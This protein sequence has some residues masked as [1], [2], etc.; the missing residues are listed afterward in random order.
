MAVSR[1]ETLDEYARHLEGDPVEAQALY[2]DCLISVTSFFR[3]PAVSSRPS[4]EQVLPLLLKDRPS[5]APLR[6][7]VPGCA[8]GE[9]VYSIA[10]CLLERTA[11]AVRATRPCRSSRTDLSEGALAEGAGGHLP[12]EHR[13][14]R[15]ARAP[16]ALLRQGGAASYQ[17]SKTIRE[18]CVFARHDLTRDSAVL[19]AST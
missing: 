18:M 14:G 9:E 11:A 16:A 7:W 8:T 15:L 17:I 6:V 19:P 10:M 4:A 2:E 3:D 1:I 12:G 5:D 13:P